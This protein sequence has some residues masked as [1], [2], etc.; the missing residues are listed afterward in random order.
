MISCFL[1]ALALLPAQSAAPSTVSLV[2]PQAVAT[3][4]GQAASVRARIAGCPAQASAVRFTYTLHLEPGAALAHEITN[5]SGQLQ[6]GYSG[7]PGGWLSV[8]VGGPPGQYGYALGSSFSVSVCGGSALQPGAHAEGY[9]LFALDYSATWVEEDIPTFMRGL[10]SW[11]VYAT[12]HAADGLTTP[13]ASAHSTAALGSG[14]T[15]TLS[16]EY[17]ED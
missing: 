4:A 17:L 2:S 1:V 5:L 16:V 8:W 3:S 9:N 7:S 10:Q 11:P 6:P 12:L 13:Y 14:I 15:A